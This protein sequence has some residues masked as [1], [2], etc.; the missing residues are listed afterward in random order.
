MLLTCI[1]INCIMLVKTIVIYI[2]L[3]V[4]LCII[5][6]YYHYTFSN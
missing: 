5:K 3:C 1:H 4:V 6:V 2:L